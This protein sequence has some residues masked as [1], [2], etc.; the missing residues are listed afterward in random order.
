M[1]SSQL[2]ILTCIEENKRFYSHL[3]R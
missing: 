2:L 1:I 3:V